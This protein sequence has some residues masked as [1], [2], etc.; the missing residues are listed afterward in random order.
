MFH[1][2]KIQINLGCIIGMIIFLMLSLNEIAFAADSTQKVSVETAIS[3]DAFCTLES[4]AQ[5]GQLVDIASVEDLDRLRIY[6][7]ENPTGGENTFRQTMD[8]VVSL[9]TYEYLEDIHRIEISYDGA[10]EA[11]YDVTD[12]NYYAEKEATKKMDAYQWKVKSWEPIGEPTSRYRKSTWSYLGE[13]HTIQ[14]IYQQTSI[15]GMESDETDTA[16]IF[17]YALKV[18]GVQINEFFS[19]GGD[20]GVLGSHLGDVQDCKG[21]AIQIM[22]LTNKVGADAGFLSWSEGNIENVRVDVNI[23]VRDV[24]ED[25]GEIKFQSGY[26]GGIVD[27]IEG[28]KT[29]CVIRNCESRGR[30]WNIN[31]AEFACGGIVGRV[32]QNDSSERA[33][34]NCNSDMKIEGEVLIAGGVVAICED[35][36]AIIADCN[37]TGDICV[38]S[39]H[40]YQAKASWSYPYA[41][42]I[43]GKT[44]LCQ[45]IFG[46]QN[47]A[48]IKS[49]IGSAGG[50]VGCLVDTGIVSSVNY[51]K[52]ITT[53]GVDDLYEQPAGGIAGSY[54]GDSDKLIIN[55]Y[56]AGE[57]HSDNSIASG[58][59]GMCYDFFYTQTKPLRLTIQNVC[60][61]GKVT[62][63][64]TGDY[65]TGDAGESEDISRVYDGRTADPA[66]LCAQLNKPLLREDVSG[67][68]VWTDLESFRLNACY[69]YDP[70]YHSYPQ[71]GQC[72]RTKWI[73]T[74][75]GAID[76]Q[77][78][79]EK[80]LDIIDFVIKPTAKPTIKPTA[81]PSAIKQ[82]KQ[83]LKIQT[84]KKW[85]APSFSLKRKK[86]YGGQRY[87]LL[88][89][90]KFQGTRVEVWAKIGA[91][92]YRKLKLSQNRISKLHGKLKFRYS[93]RHKTL[94]FKIRTYQKK[95]GKKIYS[96]KSKRK[97]IVAK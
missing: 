49:K 71:K 52:V 6:L 55:C 59:V 32:I 5:K 74:D 70:V 24:G 80:D 29:S 94:Y 27:Q 92:R 45:I 7:S 83:T 39:S 19:L 30:I 34:L 23:F 77:L 10:V 58:I 61:T 18:S 95:K 38:Y 8:I 33:I 78:V 16:G 20:A 40:E 36:A 12:G 68:Y 72:L 89:L 13:G 64:M 28:K 1:N 76:L 79:Q 85:K 86:T 41:G 25:D 66:V 37:D 21:D 82:P 90:H 56:N 22:A 9:Y 54:A 91:G 73:I 3:M 81:K 31:N 57:I 60:S 47:K 69:G 63:K 93:F 26:I 96:A 35:G 87:I 48:D 4:D 17:Q 88:T 67:G 51:G 53:I 97:R 11:Y 62:G 84:K 42:G 44:S 14:G 50:I 43:C 15:V 2:I 75:D 46:C 65:L